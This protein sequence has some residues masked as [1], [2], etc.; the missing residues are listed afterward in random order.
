[1][2]EV[3]FYILGEEAAYDRLALVC[4]IVEKAYNGGHRVYIHCAD[5][6]QARRVDELLWSFKQNSFVPH[7]MDAVDEPSPVHIGY[8]DEPS[9]EGHEDVLIN[10]AETIPDF[11]SRFH[12]LA[13][14]V[15]NGNREVGREHYRFYRERGYP[16]QD[17]RI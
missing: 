2:T 14:V 15:D 16:L 1:M 4:R 5:P 9:N 3:G 13:E 17:H 7:A 8:A 10:L 6:Q 12:R 11:F